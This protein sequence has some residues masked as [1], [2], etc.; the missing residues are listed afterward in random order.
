LIEK[1]PV[2]AIWSIR[3]IIDIKMSTVDTSKCVE[4]LRL[5]AAK[6]I[7]RALEAYELTE[8][9]D[10]RIAELIS[11]CNRG[12]KDY[13][14]DEIQ[15]VRRE[16]FDVSE[17]KKRFLTECSKELEQGI[18]TKKDIQKFLKKINWQTQM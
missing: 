12:I 17:E 10:E 3:R 5:K 18:T 13:D 14:D 2:A 11:K 4:R 1:K 9:K 15:Q 7:K 6:K 16:I 8:N